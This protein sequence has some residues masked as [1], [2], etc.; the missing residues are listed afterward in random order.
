MRYENLEGGSSGKDPVYDI[1]G[2]L[3]LTIAILL[4]VC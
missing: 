4:I 3:L 2:L 1:V